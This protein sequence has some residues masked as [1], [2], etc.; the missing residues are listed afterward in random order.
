MDKNS[1]EYKKYRRKISRRHRA[2]HPD[3]VIARKAG[4]VLKKKPCEICGSLEV[5]AHHDDYKKP[6]KVRWLC[7][8]HHE[9]V[10]TE[11]ERRRKLE[12]ELHTSCQGEN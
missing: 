2:K 1:K 8:K 4:S 12:E 6:W 11:L 5:E 3:K 7:K 10:D 9:E